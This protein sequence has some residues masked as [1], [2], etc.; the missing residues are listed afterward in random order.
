MKL[1][2]IKQPLFYGLILSVLLVYCICD[3]PTHCLKSQVA[4]TWK[5][6]RTSLEKKEASDLFKE[7]MLCGHKL[8]SHES[9]SLD[10]TSLEK[11]NYQFV[12]DLEVVLNGEDDS[13]RFSGDHQGKIG[14]WTMVYDE[15]FD[16]T[17]KKDDPLEHISYFAFLKYARTKAGSSVQSKYA[18]YCNVTLNGWYH[19]GNK[20]GCFQAHRIK[21]ING[22]ALSN[23]D[24]ETNGE[25]ENKQNITEDSIASE[26]RV[27]SEN[28]LYSEV[29]AD[30]DTYSTVSS[31]SN[32]VFSS[33]SSKLEKSSEYKPQR[34]NFS[35]VIDDQLNI[36]K[37]DSDSYA[38]NSNL[39]Y[40]T[41]QYVSSINNL[42]L[43]NDFSNFKFTQ[44][45]FKDRLTLHS[46][47]KDHERF[48]ERINAADLSW[49]A[50][51]Y[52]EFEGK[53]I[54]ELNTFAG[55]KKS[56]K[57]NSE[58]FLLENSSYAL[59][60]KKK[61][62]LKNMI[63]S[64]TFRTK[65]QKSLDL[66]KYMGEIRSQGSCG[67]CFAASTLTMLEARLRFK[68]SDLISS[69]TFRLSLDHVLRCS[70]YNQGCDGG[71]S[72]LVLKFGYENELLHENCYKEGKCTSECT[73]GRRALAIKDSLENKRVKIQ[74]YKYVGGSYGKC[75]EAS[76]IE[77]L[78]KNGPFV[79][80]FEPPYDFMHYQSGIFESRIV[81]K[82]WKSLF[83]SKPQWQKVD[84]SV[85]LV[86]YGIDEDSKIPYWKLQNS[87]G[88]NWGENGY[89]RMVRGK[90][91]L[92]IESICEAGI[93]SLED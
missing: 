57:T 26:A 54:G 53:T 52:K 9:T 1:W 62:F 8:P 34:S 7:N 19:V 29:Q 27:Q 3:I 30:V 39:N 5:F 56:K 68:Y 21:N 45:Q 40:K 31:N 87:W 48:V 33:V 38:A 59:S 44:T 89:F 91:H 2:V 49:T 75:D 46:G 72:Y 80:S 24:V 60:K 47:F 78:D 10:A 15:G 11:F 74:E 37:L 70:V 6:K 93:P 18:S 50:K 77:E 67:S 58:V 22:E 66:S 88:K 42:N 69:S 71:Y 79:V 92:G 13:A 16:I 90:D 14:K 61:S 82:N 41:P 83:Q 81:K 36:Y 20:W 12:E 63:S 55:K 73:N 4:G 64:K 25:A 76:M 23:Y 32:S 17:V 65:A 85:V 43:N 51:V 84:H 86:G 35:T 28:K